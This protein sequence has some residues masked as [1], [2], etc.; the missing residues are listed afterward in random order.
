MLLCARRLLSITKK[1]NVKIGGGGGREKHA[2]S[3]AYGHFILGE[4]SRFVAAN[5]SCASKS[6]DSLEM[7]HHAILAR[8]FV[9]CQCET[10]GHSGDQSL[11]H[12]GDDDTEKERDRI[13]PSVSH[14][15]GQSE[16]Q[17]PEE[18]GPARY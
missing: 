14:R 12:V 1:F 10:D 2:C 16:E 4:R 3:Y 9:G 5:N 13:D 18:D 7:F 8:H 6:L 17:H 11:R 15:D